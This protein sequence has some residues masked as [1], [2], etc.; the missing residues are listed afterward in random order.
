MDSAVVL[1]QHLTEAAGPIR[2]GAAADLATGDRQ[3]GNGHREA[4]GRRLAHL[5]RSCQPSRGD[6]ALSLR[7]THSSRHERA[8][9]VRGSMCKYSDRAAAFCPTAGLLECR[10]R[11]PSVITVPAP[12]L[13]VTSERPQGT[14]GEAERLP[15]LLAAAERMVNGHAFA[16]GCHQC[17]R[18]VGPAG[19][20]RA[21][22]RLDGLSDRGG[23]SI[24][25]RSAD[26]GA[27]RAD[28]IGVA[29]SSQP[30]AA[31]RGSLGAG[32]VAISRCNPATC[33]WYSSWYRSHSPR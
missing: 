25:D 26:D 15:F 29:R 19:A 16:R 6:L 2:H 10:S 18:R 28:C 22:R 21:C 14:A 9:S 32:T 11:E 24:G 1:G 4:A 3:L 8:V 30:A 33:A 17:I 31:G 23:V 27:M 7:H 13:S 12:S 5:P 20:R